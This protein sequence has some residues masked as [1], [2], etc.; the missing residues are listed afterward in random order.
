MANLQVLDDDEGPCATEGVANSSALLVIE[1]D[2]ALRDSLMEIIEG[3]GIEVRGAAD[4][5]EG[6]QLLQAGFHPK[7]ILLDGWM[8]KLDGA[9]VLAAIANDTHLASIPVVWM[10]ADTSEPPPNVTAYLEKPFRVHR[11][12]D[13][14]RSVCGG[15]PPRAA[16]AL[17]PAT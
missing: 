4:G 6:L 1:D 7:M 12:L 13:V 9:G 15:L 14:I 2:E 8:P 11:L 17:V 16:P 10:S 5:A 3:R